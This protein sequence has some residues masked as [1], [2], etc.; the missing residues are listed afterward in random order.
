MIR[1][2]PRSTRSDTLF[3]TRRSS[4]LIKA[5]GK[6][7]AALSERLGASRLLRDPFHHLPGRVEKFDTRLASRSDLQQHTGPAVLVGALDNRLLR[8]LPNTQPLGPGA[9]ISL[10]IGAHFFPHAI[11]PHF[12]GPFCGAFAHFH[13][14]FSLTL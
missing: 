4:D 10:R 2:P 14:L 9:A 6:V 3:P 12:I 1:R 8:R 11:R 13:H 7:P 5:P